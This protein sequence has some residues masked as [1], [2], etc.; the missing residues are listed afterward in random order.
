MHQVLT[1]SCKKG[2]PIG[3]VKK[4]ILSD[5]LPTCEFCGGL[6]KPDI[7]FFGEMLPERFHNLTQIDTSNTKLLLCIGTSLEVYPFAGVAEMIPW[8]VPR[9]LI[10]RDQV[11][12]FG[13][14][15]ND[16]FL[17]GDLVES[18]EKLVKCLNWSDKMKAYLRTDLSG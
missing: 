17:G 16:H 10:N 3:E 13:T 15:E 14:R 8:E 18:L 1:F 6:V 12:S 2:K 11:G 7:V 4:L 5:E 9:V